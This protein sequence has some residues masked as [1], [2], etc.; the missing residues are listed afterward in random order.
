MQKIFF[1]LK[2]KLIKNCRIRNVGTSKPGPG[3]SPP[4]T[5]PRP[6][7]IPSDPENTCPR[8][9]VEE[10]PTSSLPLPAYVGHT[11]W[12][13][14]FLV[15]FSFYYESCRFGH[16]AHTPGFP[17]CQHQ[18]QEGRYQE[19][20]RRSSAGVPAS[21]P[22]DVPCFPQ[23]PRYVSLPASQFSYSSPKTKPASALSLC[24][25]GVKVVGPTHKGKSASCSWEKVLELSCC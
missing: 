17:K 7:S 21:I 19:A 16:L 6:R 25:W 20:G 3:F 1:F 18:P 2:Y 11:A 12:Q 13:H 8:S 14:A 10:L 5:G 23:G 9:P 24:L 4:P 22:G 15:I